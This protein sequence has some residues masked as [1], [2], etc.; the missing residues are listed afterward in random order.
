[1]TVVIPTYN[2]SSVLRHAIR[3]VLAQTYTNFEL[4]VVGD[5]CTDDSA[6]VA[7]GFGDPR[8][9]W[10][11]LPENHGTQSGP[12]NVGL[13][14]AAGR[15]VAYL[16]H[17]DLWHPWHLSALVGAAERTGAGWVH[18]LIELIGPPG[19]RRKILG[20]LYPGER[21]LGRWIPP[22][23][24]LHETEHGRRLRWRH[25]SEIDDPTDLDFADRLQR[26]AGPPL[27]V[28]MLTSFKFVAT[29]RP[30]CYRDRRD[31]EQAAWLARIEREPRLLERE[32]ASVLFERL[33]PFHGKLP[34]PP[35]R[36]AGAGRGW[37]TVH[38]R[39][40]RGLE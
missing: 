40:V 39:R 1:M 5:A 14:R 2:Y 28:P 24:M 13:E 29:W 34:A 8:V 18:G 36:P 17:D 20:N 25:Y 38:S 3:S 4:L 7:M 6:D 31:D 22:T 27:C 12:N 9:E 23:S 33:S 21:P 11:N 32:L 26:E 37:L 19:S 35:E 16:G 15:Y 30:G 10:I